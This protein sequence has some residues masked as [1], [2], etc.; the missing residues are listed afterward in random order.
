MT[1][2]RVPKTLDEAYEIM[3]KKYPQLLEILEN[4]ESAEC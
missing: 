2:V 4:E 1:E 3:L